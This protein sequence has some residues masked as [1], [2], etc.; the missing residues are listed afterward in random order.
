MAY[1]EPGGEVIVSG[2]FV[3]P[4]F[5]AVTE[6][7]T[8][9]IGIDGPV[10]GRA[11]VGADGKWTLTFVLPATTPLGAYALQAAVLDA[12][13][14]LVKN[15]LAQ[16]T[17]QVGAPPAQA[18]QPVPAPA[19]DII[20]S[21]D[22][23]SSSTIEAPAVTAPARVAA[24]PAQDARKPVAAPA[25]KPAQPHRSTSSARAP[26]AITHRTLRPAP[27]PRAPEPT[28][29]LVSELSPPAVAVPELRPLAAPARSTEIPTARRPWPFDSVTPFLML[30]LVALVAGAAMLR[31]RRSPLLFDSEMH[32]REIEAE[33]QEIVAEELARRDARVSRSEA[34]P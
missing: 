10:M 26:A 20:P 15:L 23:P 32:A 16:A 9:R 6:P 27:R 8:V 25:T 30:A 7:V 1:Y 34:R 5:A 19:E 31:R 21:S 17:L 24:P 12:N 14:V 33:L 29:P 2:V 4:E 3:D 18:V 28:A 13:G 11:P 22:A